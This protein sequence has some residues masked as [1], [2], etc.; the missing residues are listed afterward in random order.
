MHRAVF[1][2]GPNAGGGKQ[3]GA[4]ARLREECRRRRQ[5]EIQ[6]LLLRVNDT[7]ADMMLGVRIRRKY[8]KQMCERFGQHPQPFYE[9]FEERTDFEDTTTDESSDEAAPAHCDVRSLDDDED[10]EEEEED[11]CGTTD[12]YNSSRINGK[13]TVKKAAAAAVVLRPAAV[14]KAPSNGRDSAAVSA[15]QPVQ[16]AKKP[17]SAPAKPTIQ[18]A[19]AAQLA[20]PAA[21]THNGGNNNG[22]TA[23]MSSA[24]TAVK[25]PASGLDLDTH[26]G[27][28]FMLQCLSD[29]LQKHDN[30]HN[31]DAL[32]AVLASK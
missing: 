18:T 20:P 30:W 19:P 17:A 15:S 12:V 2:L 26:D 6:R 29:E 23:E 32:T 10:L 1:T 7:P 4:S 14:S 28:L 24:S 11:D 21:E 22:Q 3:R 8:A 27:M 13:A 31:A 9:N 5:E 16:N 25:K